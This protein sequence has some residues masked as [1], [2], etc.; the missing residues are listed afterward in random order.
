[1]TSAIWCTPNALFEYEVSIIMPLLWGRQF[2]VDAIFPSTIKQVG[3]RR[4][5]FQYK[6]VSKSV[7]FYPIL[8]KIGICRN[9]F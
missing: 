3:H 6:S 8:T 9:K 7:R 5:D 4:K 1:V 2:H